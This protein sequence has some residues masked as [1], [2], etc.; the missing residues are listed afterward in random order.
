MEGLKLECDLAIICPVLNCVDYTKQFVESIR[1]RRNYRIILLDNGSTDGTPGYLKTLQNDIRIVIMHAPY[2][3][4]VAKSWNHGISYAIKN[5]NSQYFF[6]PNN[7]IVLEKDTI[8]KL[9]N[10]LQLPK[11]LMAT[12]TNIN[13]GK[14]SAIDLVDYRLPAIQEL[15]ENPD[16]SCFMIKKKTIENIGYFDENFF[17]AYFEDNDYHYRIKIA[18]YKA[19]KDN[20][21]IYFHYG[22]MTVKENQEVRMMNNGLYLHNKERFRKKWGGYP[23]EETL[24]IPNIK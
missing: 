14:N 23:G 9:Y 20:Q 19:I 12:A 1:T 18:G 10:D 3:R 7:D 21:N 13:D 11:I 16:F 2:N 24:M 6:I 17:P 8:E 4:G 5:F 22:S 15:T